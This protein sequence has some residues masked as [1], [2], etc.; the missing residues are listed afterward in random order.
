MSDWDSIVERLSLLPVVMG[1]T[2]TVL[3]GYV[4][5]ENVED[6]CL[7]KEQAKLCSEGLNED[8]QTPPPVFRSS[9]AQPE[10]VVQH[11]P[12]CRSK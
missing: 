2:G 4:C 8:V 12:N 3:I 6:A 7:W 11:N 9:L 1:C 5:R 10:Y